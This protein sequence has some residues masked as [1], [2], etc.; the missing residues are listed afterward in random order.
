MACK[1][2][3]VLVRRLGIGMLDTKVT[4]SLVDA[5]TKI[6]A[7]ELLSCGINVNLAP[8]CDVVTH[9]E[10]QVIGDRAFGSDAFSWLHL[11]PI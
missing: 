7:E 9:P 4:E 6:M 3:D 2:N 8:V 1:P 5:V 11:G 10:N